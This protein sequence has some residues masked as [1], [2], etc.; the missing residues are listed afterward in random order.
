MNKR[1]AA[2]AAV[3]AFLAAGGAWLFA[4][5]SRDV[6]SARTYVSAHSISSPWLTGFRVSQSSNGVSFCTFLIRTTNGWEFVC[7]R[8]D[9]KEQPW[10]LEI[11]E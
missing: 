8:I 9:K 4:L 6:E 2:Y 11:V 7:V 10:R 3:I 1:Y 5:T